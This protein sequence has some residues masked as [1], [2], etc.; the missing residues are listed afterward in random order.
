[1]L[2]NV[3]V[4]ILVLCTYIYSG[5]EE[6]KT[7]NIADVE[8]VATIDGTYGIYE[9]SVNQAISLTITKLTSSVISGTFSG[10]AVGIT[11]VDSRKVITI[12]D[13]RFDIKRK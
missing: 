10:T 1:M 5:L 8:G 12:S 9:T 3:R 2:L 7:Y 11:G 13:G 6:G 4:K